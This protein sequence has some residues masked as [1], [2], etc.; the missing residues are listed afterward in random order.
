MHRYVP[1]LERVNF[2][3]SLFG[4]VSVISGWAAGRDARDFPLPPRFRW[5]G[6]AWDYAALSSLV[7][8]CVERYEEA[9]AEQLAWR[10]N[11]LAMRGAFG[12]Q[13]RSDVPFL[14]RT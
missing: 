13:V 4:V 11:T 6:L 10:R 5:A 14:C 2:E 1:G 9:A 12:R 7:G 3:A 8:D